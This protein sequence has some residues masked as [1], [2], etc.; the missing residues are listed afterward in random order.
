MLEQQR[1]VER[2]ERRIAEPEGQAK[3]GDPARM[4]GLKPNSGRQPPAQQQPRKQRRHGFARPCMTPTHRVE[5]VRV[6][7]CPDCGAHLSDGWVQ[8]T[9]EVIELPVVPVQVTEHIYIA[10]TCPACRRRCTLPA[11][12]DGVVL[13]RQRLGANLVSRV[14]PQ[15]EEGWPPI[16][17][18][19][20]YLR[21]V[22]QLRRSVGAIV[23]AIHRTAQRAQPVVAA[24]L[25]RIRASPVVHADE[26]GPTKPAGVRMGTTVTSGLS[27]PPPSATSC[28][29]VGARRWW[30]RRWA[31]HSPECWSATA[32][33]PTTITMA[34][35]NGARRTCCGTSS[36]CEPSTPK[37]PHWPAGRRQSTSSMSR[38]KLSAIPSHDDGVPRNSPCNGNCWPAVAP[39]WLTVG[40]PGQTVPA[41]RTFHQESAPYWMR[42]TLRLRGRTRRAS[43]QQPGRAQPAPSGHQPQG[44]RR[45]PLRAGH[46]DQDDAGIP[47]RRLARP[48][49]K[50]SRRL[51]SAAHFPSSLNCY[52]HGSIL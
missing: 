11:E 43:G 48:R 21:T 18:V 14:V 7:N 22:H 29:G 27:A 42:V 52:G 20:W 6:E 19:P 35:S 36:T 17:S 10:R 51:P 40:R 16:P 4:P 23:S 47:L 2:L 5:H 28:G 34:L 8:R 41:H 38:P 49:S 24:T 30:T 39:F 44:Q 3:P 45:H 50:S 31:S 26:T 32:R 9:R 13:G 37:T 15:R 46:R 1:V 25:D 33:P 12:L